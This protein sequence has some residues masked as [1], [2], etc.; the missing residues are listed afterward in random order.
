MLRKKEAPASKVESALD[1][2][3]GG[4]AGA[5][6]NA[7]ME[8]VRSLIALEDE[9]RLPEG[10]SLEEAVQDRAFAALLAEFAPEAAVRI[11][12][13]E[14]RADEA[15]TAAKEALNARVKRQ[16]GLPQPGRANLSPAPTPD[17]MHMTSE[18][19]RA[20]ERRLKH[21]ASEGRRMKI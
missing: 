2:Q 5:S 19:F 21:G 14:K 20:L 12:A 16:T 9:N 17:Y 3:A 13:A 4:T 7:H 10:F 18:E 15:E 6:E 1:A 8:T 11:Y